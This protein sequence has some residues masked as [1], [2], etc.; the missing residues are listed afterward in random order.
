V[1]DCDKFGITAERQRE[2]LAHL[3]TPGRAGNKSG[4]AG[5][6]S[7]SAGGM[8]GSANDNATSA[9]NRPRS[10]DNMS[11]STSNPSR[12]VWEKHLWECCMCAWKS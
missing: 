1:R 12:T 4:S 9:D 2:L 6:K 8:S 11:G 3:G 7:G 10:A 5:D